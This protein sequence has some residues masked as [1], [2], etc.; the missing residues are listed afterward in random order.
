MACKLSAHS[1]G[2]RGHFTENV[3]LAHSFGIEA[4]LGKEDKIKLL[5]ASLGRNCL[6]QYSYLL[7]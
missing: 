6:M 5:T 1:F 2:N 3:V 7:L 4:G